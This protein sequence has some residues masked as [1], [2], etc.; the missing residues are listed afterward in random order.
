MVAYDRNARASERKLHHAVTPRAVALNRA[1]ASRMTGRGNSR[2]R[3]EHP[4]A[5]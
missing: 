1:R 3:W 2:I 4:N 5:G